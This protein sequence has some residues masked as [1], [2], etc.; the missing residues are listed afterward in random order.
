M[1]GYFTPLNKSFYGILEIFWIRGFYGYFFATNRLESNSA[2][3][4]SEA[5]E[6]QSAAAFAKASAATVEFVTNNWM[7]Q[8]LEMHTY[9]MS[10]AGFGFNF[11]KSGGFT[12]CSLNNLKICDRFTNN[13]PYPSPPA[14]A[15]LRR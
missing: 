3:V 1:K 9:L 7:V 15:T 14:I 2:S 6:T 4:E 11:N 10:P 8:C 12:L 13:S 5:F